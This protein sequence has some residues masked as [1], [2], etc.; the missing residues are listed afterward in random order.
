MAHEHELTDGTNI[1]SVIT[2]SHV[3]DH[4]DHMSWFRHH[5]EEIK[6]VISALGIAAHVDS[7]WIANKPPKKD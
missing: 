1:V 5:M 7:F 2:S 4:P 6:G 3:D